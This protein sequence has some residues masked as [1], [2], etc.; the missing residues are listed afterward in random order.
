MADEI[1]QGYLAGLTAI[2][3]VLA[4]QMVENGVPLE[5]LKKALDETA[6]GVAKI[7]NESDDIKRGFARPFQ[8]LDA[9]LKQK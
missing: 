5:K 2:V 8:T 3:G 1:T 9:G 7:S 4:R 6:Q